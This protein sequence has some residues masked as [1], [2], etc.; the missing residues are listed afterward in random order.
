[1]TNINQGSSPPAIVTLE[2]DFETPW[3]HHQ[4]KRLAAEVDTVLAASVELS[5]LCWRME[6]R[7][8]DQLERKDGWG[9][10][11]NLGEINALREELDDRPDLSE[12]LPAITQELWDQIP[13]FQEYAQT[14]HPKHSVIRGCLVDPA[15]G[16]PF[17][18]AIPY[19]FTNL[20]T[21]PP[22]LWV[23]GYFLIRA[24]VSLVIAPGAA[25]KTALITAEALALVTGRNLLGV[26]VHGGPYRVWI[27]N[28]EDPIDE[29]QRRIAAACIHHGIKPEDFGDRL[30]VNSGR[31]QGLCIAKQDRNGFEVLEP[32][33]SELVSELEARQ[34]DVLFVDPFVSSHGV[35]ENDNGAIDAVIKAWGRVA[36]QSGCS[37]VL[38]HH[39]RKLGGE[40]ASAESARGASAMVA[41]ARSVRVLQ[42]MTPKES[43]DAGLDSP[44]G[45]FQV[46]DDKNNLAPAAENAS[47]YHIESVPLPNGDNVG[48]V[49]SWEYPKAFA[50]IT[51][52]DLLAVQQAIA[53]KGY[54]QSDQAKDWVGYA[55]GEVLKLDMTVAANRKR[56]RTMVRTWIAN[57]ALDAVEL[58]D[59][60]R[61]PR[62]CVDVGEW[63][64]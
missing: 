35:S 42:R 34:I 12:A 9:L 32:I 33:V 11:V 58:P 4:I 40:Q 44:K 14:L 17:V 56:V 8:R 3:V 24:F 45:Y 22:R 21:L 5:D 30:Y 13:R 23:Y 61:K 26:A 52:D 60:N 18:Q 28:L 41:A 59:K 63:A 48:V 57:G 49:E 31:D 19:E 16:K 46:L 53:G 20:A 37:V 36:D 39:M 25:G 62:P 10:T 64:K 38:V 47:W 2:E 55:I 50:G 15:T 6:D 29:L 51:T 54:R 1:M 27:W 7:I 43:D